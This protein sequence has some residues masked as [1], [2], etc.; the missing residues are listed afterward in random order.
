MSIASKEEIVD[1]SGDPPKPRT[2]IDGTPDQSGGVVRCTADCSKCIVFE[3]VQRGTA[4]LSHKSE[5]DLQEKFN[6]QARGFVHVGDLYTRRL[7]EQEKS[8][9]LLGGN[10]NG[11]DKAIN[12]TRAQVARMFEN[13]RD[14]LEADIEIARRLAH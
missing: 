9:A 4:R 1:Q 10:F 3:L 12:G 7:H 14:A 8:L 13:A 6:R 11:C 5:H 2:S